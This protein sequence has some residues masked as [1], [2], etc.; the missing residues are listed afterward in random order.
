MCEIEDFGG[1]S[2]GDLL[3]FSSYYGFLGFK[4]F[5]YGVYGYGF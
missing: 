5:G 2:G 3:E 1:A 4:G